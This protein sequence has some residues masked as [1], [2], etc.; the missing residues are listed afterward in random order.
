MAVMSPM[1][2]AQR[3]IAAAAL[4][5]FAEKGSADVTVSEL[6]EAA[7]VA[8]GTIYNNLDSPERLFETVAAALADEMNGRIVKSYEGVDD[9]AARLAI[10]VRLYV[11]RAHEDP[12][13][14]RFLVHF[15]LASD[16]LRRIWAGSPLKDLELGIE[17]KRYQIAETQIPSALGM[18][19]GST[20]S[21][22]LMVLEGVKT[23]RDAGSETAELVLR[24]LGVKASEARR[25]AHAELPAL[26][27]S[28]AT[29]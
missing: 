16:S 29:R 12:V 11:K 9:P 25:I 5:L 6:A 22:A 14:G 27:P 18:L 3:R 8:R 24:G 17:K 10:G 23:W 26:A 19:A 2:A 20:L 1:N 7:G 15:G 28:G 21:A 13:W 4:K